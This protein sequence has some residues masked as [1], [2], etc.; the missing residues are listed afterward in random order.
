MWTNIHEKEKSDFCKLGKK[1]V[2]NKTCNYSNETDIDKKQYNT[3]KNIVIL[4][5]I[6]EF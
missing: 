5:I 4:M 6:N 3:L 1:K 2:Y